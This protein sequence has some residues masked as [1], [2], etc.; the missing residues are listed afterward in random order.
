MCFLTSGKRISSHKTWRTILSRICILVIGL[1]RPLSCKVNSCVRPFLRVL[2][3]M[4]SWISKNIT[5]KVHHKLLCGF[6]PFATFH[7]GLISPIQI[8]GI[9]YNFLIIHI[10]FT[11]ITIL[12]VVNC[13]RLCY[14]SCL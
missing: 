12:T 11:V 14:L 9:A 13:F 5:Q 10:L 4:S 7:R 3:I 6:F 2:L 8:I 1:T